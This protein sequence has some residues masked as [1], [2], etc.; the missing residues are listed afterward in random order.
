MILEHT[1]RKRFF[2]FGYLVLLI[3]LAGFLGA[4]NP[5]R[6]AETDPDN[7]A[8]GMGIQQ[9]ERQQVQPAIDFF[10]ALLNQSGAQQPPPEADPMK[11]DPN[12]FLGELDYYLQDNAG[13]WF[14]ML[15]KLSL[16][17]FLGLILALVYR[18]T[19]TGKRKKY[20]PSLVQSQ[21]LLSIGG[22]M[23]WIVVATSLVRAFGL[24]GMVGL[25]RYRTPVR[26]PKD[27]VMVFLS[28]GIGMACGLGQAAAA[29]VSTGFLTLV[30]F[31]IQEFGL[32]KK[33]KKK[34]KVAPEES[35]P[36]P[37]EPED[38]R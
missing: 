9:S 4:A 17:A 29:I 8:G 14:V 10:Q 22:A 32:G 30:L 6:A 11:P 3:F 34:E 25:I 7:S 19:Y 16:A 2:R 21:L 12:S 24:A 5:V 28:M 35:L 37:D 31:A 26:D 23:I 33:K 13:A 38:E 15:T 18:A 27:N 20:N 1:V 36:L